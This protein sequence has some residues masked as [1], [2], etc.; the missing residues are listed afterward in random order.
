MLRG[1]KKKKKKKEKRKKKK[2]LS[3]IYVDTSD[4]K[5]VC[6]LGLVPNSQNSQLSEVFIDISTFSHLQS[7][8]QRNF[9]NSK[10]CLEVFWLFSSTL[11]K[12]N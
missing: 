10:K 8:P 4:L 7:W 2:G 9:S 12:W 1:G 6:K 5:L 3:M 11:L